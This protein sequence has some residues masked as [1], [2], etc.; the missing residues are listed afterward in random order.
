[1]KQRVSALDLKLLVAELA[2]KAKGHRLSNVY[3]LSS[4]NRSFLFK[5]AQPDS[6]VNVAVESGFKLYITDYQKP[7]LPQPTSFCTK[8]RKH[9]KSKRLTHVEQIGDDRVVVLEFSDGMYYLVLEFFSAGN[10]ILL[11]SNR[12]IISLFRVVENKMKASDPDAFNYSIGQTY[13]SF[14]STLFEDENMK[15][16]E[17]VTYDKGLVVGWIKE[18]QQ[19]EEQNKNR[20]TSGKKKK[21][22]GRIFSVNKLCF[23]HAPYLSSDLIQRSLLDNGV[24]PSQ[25]CLN[26]LEDNSLVEKVVTSLQESENTFKSLL[27]TP[28]GKV[29]GW[30]LRKINPLFDNT[31]EESSENLKY[32]YEE[33]HP[34][35]PVHKEN[36]DSK[37]DVVDGYNKTVDTFF[38]MIELSK[39]SLSRQQQK[40]AAA[41]RLQLVKEENEK[42]LA[43]LDAVQELNRKKG[44]LITLHSSEIEDCRSSIQALLDQQMDWQNIDKLIEVERRRGNPT[45]KMINSLNLLKHEFTVLLP[46]EQEVVDDENEDESDSD[47]DSDSDDDDDDDDDD[48]TEDKKSNIISVSIDIRE[49]AF[50]NST[51]YFD[52]KKNAQ[53]KQE[54]TKENAAIAIKNSEMKIHRDMKRLENES[55]N[56]VDIRKI[57]PKFWF[58]KYFWF[59]SSDGYLCIAGK[60]DIQIDS[61]YYRYLDNNTDYLVSSD[62][63]KSLKVVIKNPYKNK[64]IPPSTFVQ[65]GIYCLT[66]SKAWDSKMSPSPWFVKG[67]A[68]SKKDFDGS[69]LPPGLL[70]IKGDKNFLPPSQLV[71]GI[72]LLWL[73]DEKTKARHI[74]YMLNRNKDIGFEYAERYEGKNMKM[75]ELAALLEKLTLKSKKAKDNEEDAD[76]EKN[77]DD[78]DDDETKEDVLQNSKDYTTKLSR[79]KKNKLKKIKRKY[80]DQDDEER[81]LRMAAL[82]TL[83][84][85]DNDGEQ[86]GSDV[87]GESKVDSREQKIVEASMRKEKKKQQQINQLQHLLEEI[88]NAISESR[89][90]TTT[91][92]KKVYYSELFGLLNKPGKD[93][94][95]ADCIVVFMPWGA[96]NKYLYKVKVQ[97]GTNKKGKTLS[98]AIDFFKKESRTLKKKGVDWFDK[99]LIIE[100]INPQDYLM[101]MTGNRYRLTTAGAEVKKNKGGKGS[102]PKKG[103]RRK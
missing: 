78:N 89:E 13:P 55:K 9:L 85:N 47:S 91:D 2:P 34:F 50:A 70:N 35:E 83:N 97:S 100:K 57:R 79:G 33:F 43:K 68:V 8:L 71:M 88:E 102:K 74:E 72:G 76:S 12:Q 84:Q 77:E 20:E 54:K 59:I 48:E 92:V 52:A 63:D 28:P 45:A 18:M 26:M 29:Q 98:A 6:K 82:G 65:A 60:D 40:A 96:L 86:I 67:D 95:I 16:R 90:D 75:K 69:L 93:D 19:R 44:Y 25:S 10:I 4:N 94:N 81:R 5:F 15:I 80:K 31:K 23:M 41:K 7:V 61:I 36:E 58:E 3:S 62:V 101:S 27:Q 38:T 49:S 32:T 46:D 42:K 30:I 39:A 17:F 103:R 53:E 99:D 14:D 51:R 64:E 56:T 22:K 1:M 73:P 21:K 24:T 11:D 37:V 87:N 66:T